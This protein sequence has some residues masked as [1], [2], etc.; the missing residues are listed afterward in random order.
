[1]M[2]PR[3][4][5]VEREYMA[6]KDNILEKLEASRDVLERMGV[7]ELALFG[8]GARGER[9]ESSDLDFFVDFKEK[10]FDAYMELK[11]FL[12]NLFSCRVDLVIK[13]AIKPRLRTRILKEALHAEGF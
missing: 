8:S 2:N 6:L 12:E 13:S 9:S 3:Q 7:R 11:D 5:S 4:T 10:S 1:M